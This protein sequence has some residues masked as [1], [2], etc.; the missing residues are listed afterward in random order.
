[1]RPTVA[2]C[3]EADDAE[4]ACDSADT[5]QHWLWRMPGDAQDAGWH[6]LCPS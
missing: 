6:L 5:G 3:S 4:P 2:L 1:M